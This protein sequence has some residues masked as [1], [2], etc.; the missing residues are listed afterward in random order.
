MRLQNVLE[1]AYMRPNAY[2][3]IACYPLRGAPHVTDRQTSLT[4]L[5][6]GEPHSAGEAHQH[7]EL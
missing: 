3:T 6:A 4:D 2:A 1:A 5:A 7:Q